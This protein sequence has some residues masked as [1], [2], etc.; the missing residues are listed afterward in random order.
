[1]V[2]FGVR[3]L[4][5][6]KHSKESGDGAGEA[7][8]NLAAV[9]RIVSREPD[10]GLAGLVY[11]ESARFG[12]DSPDEGDAEAAPH[13]GFVEELS[14]AV[15]WGGNFDCQV[16]GA[17]EVSRDIL[18]EWQSSGGDEGD[19]GFSDGVGISFE[20]E[21]YVGGK[22]CSHLPGFDKSFQSK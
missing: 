1:M 14:R 9:K 5:I 20:Q 17:V 18:I 22:D 4:H 19:V 7:G 21:S 15:A 16:R 11:V 2:S 6:P 12:I 8:Q 3:L 13:A 10:Q